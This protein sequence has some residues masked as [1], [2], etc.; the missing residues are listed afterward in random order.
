[1]RVQSGGPAG[2]WPEA[3]QCPTPYKETKS[4]W[5]WNS[6]PTFPGF[7]KKNNT[8]IS[9]PSWFS[10]NVAAQHTCDR[11]PPPNFTSADP[12]PR[13]TNWCPAAVYVGW[14]EKR[15]WTPLEAP[16]GISC[17]SHASRLAPIGYMISN[18]GVSKAALG[19]PINPRGVGIDAG[20]LQQNNHRLGG[21][22]SSCGQAVYSPLPA[23]NESFPLLHRVL[24]HTPKEILSKSGEL[25][26]FGVRTCLETVRN[27]VL[28][29][30]PASGFRACDV[31]VFQ[32]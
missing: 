25:D 14:L 30:G 6:H 23:C 17:P 29:W 8:T 11:M 7:P 15:C 13:E 4:S 9:Q 5:V 18:A 1:M 3:K 16:S 32:Q 10:Q 22:G 27:A 31:R 19:Q 21:H 12:P 26:G 24:I 20:M 2:C 28:W